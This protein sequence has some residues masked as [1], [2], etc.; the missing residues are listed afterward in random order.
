MSLTL[1]RNLSSMMR[2]FCRNVFNYN[3]FLVFFRV[4]EKKFQSSL[5]C[6]R[7]WSQ[8]VCSLFSFFL[9]LW[10]RQAKLNW[11]IF[12]SICDGGARAG[13]SSGRLSKMSRISAFFSLS[14]REKQRGKIINFHDS[15][16]EN[17]DLILE[18]MNI[19]IAVLLLRIVL[20]VF[21][22]SRHLR[23]HHWIELR[24]KMK[25]DSNGHTQKASSRV[26]D[27]ARGAMVV[28]RKFNNALEMFSFILVNETERV[29]GALSA[30]VL[31]VI[32]KWEER[33]KKVHL[34]ISIHQILLFHWITN[35]F[36]TRL[37]LPSIYF[38]LVL[39]DIHIS[40][41]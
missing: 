30:S 23:L 32:S 6:A 28:V 4:Y 7:L 20:F 9:S 34:L 24:M 11:W 2:I 38:P 8:F 26:Q 36:T 12:N 35:F 29:V 16:I 40:R 1:V 17:S 39:G 14:C 15:N 41:P 25:N 21:S 27:V 19:Y 37:S 10:H 18:V 33:E 13:G 31:V 3:F 5:R 22:C